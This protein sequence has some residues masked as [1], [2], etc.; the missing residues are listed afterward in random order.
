MFTPVYMWAQFT[1]P[2][3]HQI[4]LQVSSIHLVNEIW[5]QSYFTSLPYFCALSIRMLY[6]VPW[7]PFEPFK[8]SLK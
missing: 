8:A 6:V 3:L 7:V 5:L 4:P 1:R 2:M